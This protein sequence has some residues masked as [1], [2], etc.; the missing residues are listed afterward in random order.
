MITKSAGLEAAADQLRH[1]TSSITR[2]YYVQQELQMVDN[3]ASFDGV[4]P[5]VAVSK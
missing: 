4:F 2:E 3:R 5:D 1:S